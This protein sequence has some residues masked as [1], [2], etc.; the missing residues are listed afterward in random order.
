MPWEWLKQ[1]IYCWPL[2]PLQSHTVNCMPA[3]RDMQEAYK[4][5][6]P[7]HMKE[8][9]SLQG[10][11]LAITFK[12]QTVAICQHLQSG[13]SK[14]WSALNVYTAE[15]LFEPLIFLLHNS[16]CLCLHLLLPKIKLKGYRFSTYDTKQQEQLHGDLHLEGTSWQHKS[17]PFPLLRTQRHLQTVLTQCVMFKIPSA[18]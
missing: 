8:R 6:S 16:L 11:Q 7:K 9:K 17:M 2:N 4:R 1:N 15:A 12:T 10:W 3:W 13:V 18:N 5:Q 14:W